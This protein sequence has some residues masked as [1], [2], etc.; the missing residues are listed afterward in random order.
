MNKLPAHNLSTRHGVSPSCVGLPAGHW[1]T[2]TEF[3]VQRFP[4]ITREVWL[5]RMQA[6]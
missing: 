6:G 1:P 2:I 3:L 4:A 5:Q